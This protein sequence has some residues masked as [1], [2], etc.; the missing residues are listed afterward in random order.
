MK[1]K[2][3]RKSTQSRAFAAGCDVFLPKPCLPEIL[4]EEA[5]RLIEHSR[6]LR[7]TV[8]AVREHGRER[9]RHAKA[10][11]ES[12]NAAI[13]EDRRLRRPKHR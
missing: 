8:A 2:L 11:L 3:W 1:A 12:T 7:K 4:L 5:K 13:E 10:A 9:V 6:R